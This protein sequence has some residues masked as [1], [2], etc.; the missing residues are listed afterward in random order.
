MLNLAREIKEGRLDA[1][2]AI[3][4]ASRQCAGAE[5]ARR[6]GYPVETVPYAAHGELQLEEYSRRITVL[7]NAAAVDLV[8]MAG[9]LSL[10]LI[11]DTYAGKVVNIHPALLPKFGG[12]GY[13]G[14][15]VHEAVLAAGERESGC[16][17]HYVNNEYDA[18][19]V[20]LQ[21]TVPVNPGDSP[22]DLA[23]RV[24]AEECIAYPEAIRICARNM[25]FGSR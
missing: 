11:P 22:D 7:L 5:R 8:V 2:I 21:R 6:L 14:H 18:G 4:I 3:V 16:T 20:I 13:Y 12:K 25:G 10:W 1:T 24:F 15:R 23:A 19:P 17:V 9:F